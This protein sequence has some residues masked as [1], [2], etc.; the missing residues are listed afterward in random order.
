MLTAV[1]QTKAPGYTPLDRAA[2]TLKNVDV[3]II[4]IGIGSGVNKDELKQIG[5]SNMSIIV[6]KS[7]NDLLPVGESLTETVFEEIQG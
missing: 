3:R 1:E 6:T 4:A 7:F 2:L 5:N